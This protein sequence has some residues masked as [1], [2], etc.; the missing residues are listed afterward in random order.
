MLVMPL[1]DIATGGSGIFRSQNGDWRATWEGSSSGSQGVQY[2]VEVEIDE[3][4]VAEMPVPNSSKFGVAARDGELEVCGTIATVFDDGVISL[5][6]HPGLVLV[7]TL[8]RGA[9]STGQAIRLRP[10]RIAIYPTEDG[11]ATNVGIA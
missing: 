4:L 11:M 6:L 8:N 5:D 1:S 10:G 2:N 7:E 9:L 3:V